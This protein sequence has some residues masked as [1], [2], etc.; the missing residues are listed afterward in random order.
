M[1]TSSIKSV[2]G[3]AR[4]LAAIL[5]V[6]LMVWPAFGWESR[7]THQRLTDSAVAGARQSIDELLRESYAL[8]EGANESFRLSLLTD[9]I[10][11][12]VLS[13]LR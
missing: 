4:G 12:G 2:R 10:Y 13:T 3:V 9:P 11:D 5:V 7:V 6:L 1:T 8:E